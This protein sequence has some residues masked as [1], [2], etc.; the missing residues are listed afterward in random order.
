MHVDLH[1]CGNGGLVQDNTWICA[2]PLGMGP[3]TRQHLD[4]QTW[5]GTLLKDNIW[6]CTPGLGPGTRKI[7]G[8]PHLDWDLEH[9][10]IWD[11]HTWLDWDLKQANTWIYT[12]GLGLGEWQHLDLHTWNGTWHR[13]TVLGGGGVVWEREKKRRRRRRGKRKNHLRHKKRSGSFCAL[14]CHRPFV[15]ACNAQ[16]FYVMSQAWPCIFGVLHPQQ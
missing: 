14:L 13:T 16:S 9:D 15:C 4:L 3:G 2:D 7:S 8:F 1:T 11:L 10:N 12:P 6:I 5:N